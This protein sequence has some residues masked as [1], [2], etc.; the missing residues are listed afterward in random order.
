[1]CRNYK[2]INSQNFNDE[3]KFVFSKKVDPNSK[4]NQMFLNVVS[5]HN[6]LKR[7]HLQANHASFVQVYLKWYKEKVLPGKCLFF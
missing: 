3:L 7:K 5:R 1:M 2:Y 4:F 6:I